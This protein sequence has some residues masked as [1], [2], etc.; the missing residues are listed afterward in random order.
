M[1][2]KNTWKKDPMCLVTLLQGILY[3]GFKFIYIL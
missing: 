2:K 1:G 3:G